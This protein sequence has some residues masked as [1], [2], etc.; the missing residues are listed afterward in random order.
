MANN[1]KLGPIQKWNK[2]KQKK[3]QQQKTLQFDYIIKILS[4]IN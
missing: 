2:K 3:Q 4:F 1:S